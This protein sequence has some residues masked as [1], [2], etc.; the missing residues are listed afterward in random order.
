M[1]IDRRELLQEPLSEKEEPL[2]KD[3][4]GFITGSRYA[5]VALQNLY[6]L[7]FRS[8]IVFFFGSTSIDS[9]SPALN[10]NWESLATFD[11]M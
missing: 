2:A 3:E 8:V 11:G 9:R 5:D 4:K 7:V 6:F 10:G 1:S